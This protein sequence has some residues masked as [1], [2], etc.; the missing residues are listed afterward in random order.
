MKLPFQTAP[1]LRQAY[2]VPAA[3]RIMGVTAAIDCDLSGCT[4]KDSGECPCSPGCMNCTTC[5]FPPGSH[6]GKCCIA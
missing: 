5:V 4:C 1:V 6:T 2:A 3:I